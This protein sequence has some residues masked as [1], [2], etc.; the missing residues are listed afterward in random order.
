MHVLLISEIHASTFKIKQNA[1]FVNLRRTCI[2]I[3]HQMVHKYKITCMG[4]FVRVKFQFT[5]IDLNMQFT[6][7]LITVTCNSCKH[8][9]S[10]KKLTKKSRVIF[11]TPEI[12]CFKQSLIYR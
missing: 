4:T 9:S 12:R 10:T 11:E 3:L 1:C 6:V 2:N 7:F 8:S 5:K